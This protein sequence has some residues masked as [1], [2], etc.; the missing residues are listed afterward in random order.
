VSEVIVM[1]RK[2]LVALIAVVAM[3]S[4]TP[5]AEATVSYNLDYI[6]SGNTPDSTSPWG[7]ISFD[8]I[9]G[10]VRV[11]MTASLEDASEFI[12]FWGF[13]VNNTT[14]PISGLTIPTSVSGSAS[15]SISTCGDADPTDCNAGTFKADGDGFFRIVVQFDSSAGP[16]RLE[17]TE[18]VSFDITGTGLVETDFSPLSQ[19]GNNGAYNTAAHIQGITPNC[20]GWAGNNS[21]SAGGS[22]DGPCSTTNVPEPASLLLLGSGLL[23]VSLAGLRLRRR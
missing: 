12:T 6:F 11:T 15:G 18:S 22:N 17:G 7:T 23:G 19:G 8:N 14:D 5:A 1:L 4:L 2:V 13:N 16:G 3:A 9:T 10:G 21:A 20:S